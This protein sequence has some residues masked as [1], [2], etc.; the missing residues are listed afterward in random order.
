MG[1]SIWGL[2]F[3]SWYV[4]SIDTGH[5]AHSPLSGPRWSS[6]FKMEPVLSVSSF[7]KP[8][9]EPLLQKV[10]RP[11]FSFEN[12]I[13]ISFSFCCPH[14]PENFPQ[15]QLKSNY[16]LIYL[17]VYSCICNFDCTMPSL[18]CTG[19]SGYSTQA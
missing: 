16:L 1:S 2:W 8:K 13:I 17:F 3:S 18:W 12:D 5:I 10:Y 14:V 15:V 11:I 4:V 7:S 19:F 6:A 9:S